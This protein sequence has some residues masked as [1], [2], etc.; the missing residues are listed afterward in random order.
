MSDQT[1]QVS[2]RLSGH[3]NRIYLTM[4]K[5]TINKIISQK[6]EKTRS[7]HISNKLRGQ[8]LF[9]SFVRPRRRQLRP[10]LSREAMLSTNETK[11]LRNKKS[12]PVKTWMW[13]FNILMLLFL[14]SPLL[15][16][17]A[18]L[19]NQLLASSCLSAFLSVHLS[20]S[21]NSAYTGRIVIIFDIWIFSE[22]CR[23]NA[24]FIKV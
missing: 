4:Q 10:P 24:S 20:A 23:N 15:V 1:Q 5:I 17:F 19:R 22:I 14:Y 6:C 2:P 3:S 12:L 8:V 18:K 7:C 13:K 9:S 21:N 16:T 11:G